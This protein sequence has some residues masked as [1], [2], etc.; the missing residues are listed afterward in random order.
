MVQKNNFSERRGH[1][2]FPIRD[3]AVVFNEIN[4]GEIID[5][6]VG[7][8]SFRTIDDGAR[9]GEVY[10][11]NILVSRDGFTLNHLPCKTVAEFVLTKELVPSTRLERR[12]CVEF[13]KLTS[14][15]ITRIRTFIMSNVLGQIGQIN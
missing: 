13:G 9:A 5:I 10:N 3:G 14:E 15:Q 8:L 7:G 1:Q 6:S 12:V 11:L 4:I 2:R